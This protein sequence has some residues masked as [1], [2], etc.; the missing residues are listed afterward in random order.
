MVALVNRKTPV[1]VLALSGAASSHTGNTNETILKTISIPAGAMGANGRVEVWAQLSWTSTANNKTF[2]VRL[3]GIGG[4]NFGS[5]AVT[6]TG[7]GQLLLHIDNRNATNSQ[8]GGL[9]SSSAI[10][11]VTSAVDT[12]AAVDLVITGQLGTGTD[13]V[14]VE[15]VRAVV[16]PGA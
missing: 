3:G 12:T 14:T 5:Y 7:A 10:A 2:R 16:Y 11:S 4:T 8:I 1:Q 9:Y 15:T 13:T 6:T